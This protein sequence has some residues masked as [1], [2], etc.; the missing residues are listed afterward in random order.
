M[1]RGMPLLSAMVF[2]A[3]YGG[4][5]SGLAPCGSDV[6]E[7]G[8]QHSISGTISILIIDDFER[9]EAEVLV[10][11][12]DGQRDHRLIFEPSVDQRLVQPQARVRATGL[13]DADCMFHVERLEEL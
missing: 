8:G 6:L 1:T 9:G 7:C 2:S 13:F 10:F 12:F 5:A 4:C 11:L 3:V